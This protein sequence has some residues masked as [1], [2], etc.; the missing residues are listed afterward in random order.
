MAIEIDL[1]KL[2]DQ[3]KEDVQQ[4]V[5]EAQQKAAKAAVDEL[6]STSPRD[7][8]SGKKYYRGW[9]TRKKGKGLVVYNKNKPQ[10]TSLLENGHATRN[11]KR[12]RAIP[13][14]ASAE[15]TASNT[16]EAALRKGLS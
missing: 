5:D 9:T 12:T 2:L 16:F 14:I 1:S 6:T 15:K 4:N 11:G 13:H 3:Y 10:L 7:T 8:Q